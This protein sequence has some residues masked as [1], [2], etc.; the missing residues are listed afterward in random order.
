MEY[1][2]THHPKHI[3]Q[4]KVSHTSVL[5]RATLQWA[6]KRRWCNHFRLEEAK[7]SRE[8]VLRAAEGMDT[9]DLL[10]STSEAYLALGTRLRGRSG[11]TPVCLRQLSESG[12]HYVKDI[13]CTVSQHVSRIKQQ[14]SKNVQHTNS[15][16]IYTL[17]IFGQLGLLRS[18]AVQLVARSSS[19]W[20]EARSGR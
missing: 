6:A 20:S 19:P 4:P 13:V 15:M 10:D 5:L 7:N 8:M 1:V 2:I 14:R 9:D 11:P 12:E 18:L 16:D 3:L 17:N